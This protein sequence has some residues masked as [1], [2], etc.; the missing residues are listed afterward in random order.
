MNDQRHAIERGRLLRWLGAAVMVLPVTLA[1]CANSNG[2]HGR[3]QSDIRG[4]DHRDA[5]SDH[6]YIL[7]RTYRF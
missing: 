4:S 2:P 3:T 7:G 1:A 6:V 5:Q